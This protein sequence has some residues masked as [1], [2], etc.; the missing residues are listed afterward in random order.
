M[1]VSH[2]FGKSRDC[3]GDIHHSM[4]LIQAVA[5]VHSSLFIHSMILICSVAYAHSSL[6]LSFFY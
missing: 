3:Y 5:Y 4:T 1:E 6:L 2:V